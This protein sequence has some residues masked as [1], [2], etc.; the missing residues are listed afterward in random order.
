MTIH[1]A[2]DFQ[3][4]SRRLTGIKAVSFDV[5]GTLLDFDSVMRSSLAEVLKELERLDPE[6]ASELTVGRLIEIRDRVY[7]E[8]KGKYPSLKDVRREGFLQA[9]RD[10]GRPD[11]GL[12]LH[13]N[14]L[15]FRHRYADLP[16][17]DDVRPT[18]KELAGNHTLGLLSNGNNYASDLGLDD[19][20]EF[21]VYSE[22]HGG[23]EKPD[24]ELFQIALDEAGCA[25]DELVHVGDSL[26]NDVGGARN[27]GI[28]AIWL[29][30]TGAEPGAGFNSVPEIKSLRE[31]VVQHH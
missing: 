29:N 28:N 19:L 18:L 11:N 21:S 26:E 16:L 22:Q 30:R 6:A 15:Y 12:G 7:D 20:V 25:P 3:G 31:L 14:E 24:L 1:S 23:I 9:L 13:L 5:D 4:V 17:F 8:L 10:V 2:R 27:V